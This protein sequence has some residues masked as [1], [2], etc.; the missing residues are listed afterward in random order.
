[1]HNG[2]EQ[3]LSGLHLNTQALADAQ[4]PLS[5]LT[6][7]E[8]LPAAVLANIR[9]RSARISK[10]FEKF[11]HDGIADGSLRRFDVRTLSI[12]GAGAFG[13][14]PKWR[15]PQSGPAPRAIADELVALFAHG[16]KRR[17]R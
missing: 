10:R 17:K 14:V 4:A 6:G 9:S 8:V 3:T 16:I 1:G 11:N 13:W 15:D 5:P 12:A 7:L 2:L